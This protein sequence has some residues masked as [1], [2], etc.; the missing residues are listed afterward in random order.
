[1]SLSAPSE[2]S[3]IVAAGELTPRIGVASAT[4][5]PFALPRARDQRRSRDAERKPALGYDVTGP[6]LDESCASGRPENS[7][8]PR[9]R[10]GF[11]M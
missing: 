9:K 4:I 7:L 8:S 3:I 11:G 1:M 6:S 10:Q 5:R 2:F